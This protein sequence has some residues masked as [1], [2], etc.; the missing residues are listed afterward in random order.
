MATQRERRDSTRSSILVAARTLFAK[1]GYSNT[2]IQDILDAADI[3]RGALYHHFKT[4]EDI[5]AVVF[6]T[7]S[8]DAVREAGNRIPAGSSPRAS[9]IAGCVAWLDVVGER[10]FGQILLIDGPLALGWERARTLEETTS[11]GAMRAA[12]GRAVEDGEVEVGSVDLAARLINATLT[13]AALSIRSNHA[14]DRETT[15]ALITAMIEG[16]VR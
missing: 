3:S 7:T 13:E 11:L 2:S 15:A 16:L 1:T 10:E 6:L 8:A 4:K 5:F 14:P 12:V 9:L